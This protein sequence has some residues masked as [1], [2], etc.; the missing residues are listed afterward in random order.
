MGKVLVIKGADFS[1]VSAGKIEQIVNVFDTSKARRNYAVTASGGYTTIGYNDQFVITSFIPIPADA[2]K[3][4]WSGISCS[5]TINMKFTKS[6]SDDESVPMDSKYAMIQH[7]GASSNAE[8]EFALTTQYADGYRYV[9]L[10]VYRGA[11]GTAAT[12]NLSN[13]NIWFK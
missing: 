3:V 12:A 4:C 11:S 8:G 1:A 9:V 10:S 7:E 2:Q 13:V 6:Q 5:N